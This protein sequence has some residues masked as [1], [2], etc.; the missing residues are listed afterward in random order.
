VARRLSETDSAYAEH[1]YL[2][3]EHHPQRFTEWL[4]EAQQAGL[5]YLGDAIPASTA[6][7]LLPQEA[8]DRAQGMGAA[9]AQELVDFVRCTAFRRALLVR[10]E[11]CDALGWRWPSRLDPAALGA[12]RVASRLRPG[13]N[14]QFEAAEIRVFVPDAG[15]RRALDALA[16]A[17]PR[18]LPFG[19]LAS[20][21]GGSPDE[22]KDEILDLWLATGAIDLHQ[23]EPP[24]ADGRSERVLAC[25]VARWHAVHGGTITNRWHQEVVLP[26]RAVRFLLG[27]LDG[28]R[29]LADLRA[30]LRDAFPAPG[31][32]DAELDELVRAGVDA[33]AASAL[34][35]G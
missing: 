31:V 33:L 21:V 28:T 7:E 18:S 2:A 13:Q 26:D 25:G 20:V 3:D 22:L 23:H 6:L 10:A 8:R 12:L 27:R 9:E 14:G 24:I 17:A 11:D 4:T 34:L 15:T 30:D 32:T 5:R 16:R 19:D 29:T 35:V 1:E